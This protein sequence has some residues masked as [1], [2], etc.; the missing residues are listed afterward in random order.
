MVAVAALLASCSDPVVPLE[1]AS[2]TRLVVRRFT[3][4]NGADLIDRTRV[5]DLARDEDCAP[6]RWSDGLSY[7]TPDAGEVVYTDGQCV[8]PVARLPVDSSA[9]YAAALAFDGE[10]A[11]LYRVGAPFDLASSEVWHLE[12][13]ICVGSFP[14]NAAATFALADEQLRDAFAP[15]TSVARG[16]GRLQI[17]DVTSADGLVLPAHYHDR[18][19]AGECV[20]ARAPGAPATSC[21]PVATVAATYFAD[22]ACTQPVAQIASI[23]PSVAIAYPQPS[24]CTAYAALGA[25]VPASA[26]RSF[27]TC[28]PEQGDPNTR[29]VAAGAPL[30]LAPVSRTV[31]HDAGRI[32]RIDLGDGVL[33]DSLVYDAMLDVDC[34][35]GL[36][37]G[38]LLCLPDVTTAETQARFTDA[39]CL[40]RIDVAVLPALPCSPKIAFVVDGADVLRRIM[41]PVTG[42]LYAHVAAGCVADVDGP[43]V[44]AVSLPIPTTQLE[45]VVL[46]P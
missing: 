15:V 40:D 45:P 43:N 3:F 5:H 16:E 36:L 4:T 46:A 22:T 26:L 23:T 17:V 1:A 25:D 30:D 13:G 19:V 42:S 6:R 29:Y 34:E 32:R 12:Q 35:P 33:T 41:G 10:V 39:A 44:V 8:T 9:R 7:C 2:G 38:S 11:H 28:T 24:G 18:T 21:V 27:E 37:G 14:G 20:A 31:A